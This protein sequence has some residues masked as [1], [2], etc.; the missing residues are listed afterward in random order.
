MHRP[1]LILSHAPLSVCRL[2]WQM[3]RS[4]SLARMGHPAASMS[5]RATDASQTAWT[6]TIWPAYRSMPP[7]VL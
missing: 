3:R 7:F 5:L 4:G 6:W 1:A 2:G